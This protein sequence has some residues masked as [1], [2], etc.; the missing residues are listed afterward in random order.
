MCKN[1]GV[2]SLVGKNYKCSCVLGFFG[3]NCQHKTLNS[4]IF[5]NSTIL[6]NEKSL[7]LVNLIG[8]NKSSYQLL[9]Q[10]SRDGFNASIFHSKCDGIAGTL[11]II[12]AFNSNIFGGY[13]A[14]NWSGI[15]EHKLDTTA[16]IFS[17]V[18]K[19]NVS[20]KMNI[21]KGKHAIYANP[22][23]GFVFAGG[24]D[25]YCDKNQCYSTL[26]YSYQLPNFLSLGSNEANSFLA[27]KSTFKPVEIEVYWIE[28]FLN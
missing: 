24:W 28:R 8:F 17:L 13:T 9:Y 7:D 26:G 4:T 27:G 23:Y 12:K 25:L 1:D 21:I 16:F 2:C 18:N 6:T 14:A 22:L 3:Q 10:S 19:Y 20:V 15:A 11:T 5:K